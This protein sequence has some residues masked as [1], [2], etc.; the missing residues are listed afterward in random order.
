MALDGLGVCVFYDFTTSY[1]Y[2]HYFGKQADG[3]RTGD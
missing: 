3:T 1:C 2:F